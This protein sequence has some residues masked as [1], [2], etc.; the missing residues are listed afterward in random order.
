MLVFGN[1]DLKAAMKVLIAKAEIYMYEKLYSLI[2]G[3]TYTNF[4][5]VIANI[6]ISH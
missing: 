5:Q 2:K 6:V 4:K 1:W 3:K